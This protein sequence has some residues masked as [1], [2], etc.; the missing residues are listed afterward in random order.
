MRKKTHKRNEFTFFE[1]NF[2]C[3]KGKNLGLTEILCK[4]KSIRVN[5]GSF[6][7]KTFLIWE[8]DSFMRKWKHIK[9]SYRESLF[10][11]WECFLYWN[12]HITNTSQTLPLAT[13]IDPEALYTFQRYIWFQNQNPLSYIKSNEWFINWLFYLVGNFKAKQMPR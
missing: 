7:V 6:W 1:Q 5:F 12:S 2:T 4:S 10:S 3:H 13:I 11:Q 9:L 8:W